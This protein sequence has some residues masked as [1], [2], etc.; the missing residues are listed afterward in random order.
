MPAPPAPDERLRRWTIAAPIF[1]LCSLLSSTRIL[2]DARTPDRAKGSSIDVAARS[3]QRFAVLKPSLP[4]RGVIGYIGK[5]GAL[6][7][8]DYYRAEYALAPLVVDDSPNHSLV[9][10][11]FPDE[12][13]L[14]PPNLQL[15]KDFGN[16]VALFTNPLVSDKDAN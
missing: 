9:L 4:Q 14:A 16:G 10:A 7:R 5:P 2:W 8:G 13:L 1:I 12:P 3:D 11:N 6:A 15:V